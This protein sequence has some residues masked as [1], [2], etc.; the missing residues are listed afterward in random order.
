MSKATRTVGT[1]GDAGWRHLSNHRGVGRKVRWHIGKFVLPTSCTDKTP[2]STYVYAEIHFH[3]CTPTHIQTHT[4]IH[5]LSLSLCVY[6]EGKDYIHIQGMSCSRGRSHSEAFCF[7][8]RWQKAVAI[9]TLWWIQGSFP[10]VSFFV[11]VQR[12]QLG[13]KDKGCCILKEGTFAK[14]HINAAIMHMHGLT[15]KSRCTVIWRKFHLCALSFI[16]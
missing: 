1:L 10:T 15:F 8:S 5:R 12:I 14:A 9:M 11:H 6:P 16:H 7:S 13:K 4:W 2:T 3:C